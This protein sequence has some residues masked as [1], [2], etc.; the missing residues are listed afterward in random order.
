MKMEQKQVQEKSSKISTM[1]NLREKATH[2]IPGF[3]LKVYRNDFNENIKEQIPWHWHEELELTFVLEGCARIYVASSSYLVQAGAGMFFNSNAFHRITSAS[4]SETKLYSIVFH[5]GILGE[6]KSYLLT[7]RYI[8]PMISTDQLK[9]FVFDKGENWHNSILTKLEEICNAYESKEYAYEYQIHNRICDIWYELLL[10]VWRNLPVEH[11][12]K[13]SDEQ[14][15]Y[16]ALSYIREHLTEPI[17]IKEI[18]QVM[19]VEKSECF[20][21][22]K[23][24]L[25]M[26]PIDYLLHQR[27]SIAA[28][29]LRKT[30]HSVSRVATECGFNSPSYFCKI[31]HR[32][33]GCTPLEYRKTKVEKP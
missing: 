7:S 1:E 26:T 9:A 6:E 20:R 31:F 28:T 19:H 16:P 25:M 3:P 17:T 4:G 30:D 23:R 10:N 12:D 18:C 29:L 11:Q 14:R 13:N 8:S 15:I 32:I 5:P 33:M 24:C 22:F 2:G 21:S 27:V